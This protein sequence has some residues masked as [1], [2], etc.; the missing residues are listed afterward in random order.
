MVRISSLP[1]VSE[2]GCEGPHSGAGCVCEAHFGFSAPQHSPSSPG[3]S[4]TTADTLED[5][6][7]A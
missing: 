1:Q 3:S 7:Q 4:V 5:K 2:K 6:T